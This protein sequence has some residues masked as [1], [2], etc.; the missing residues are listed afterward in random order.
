ML[1]I[2]EKRS[3]TRKTCGRGSSS[4]PNRRVGHAFIAAMLASIW[5]HVK[6][7]CSNIHFTPYINN[8]S[9]VAFCSSHSSSSM[10]SPDLSNVED[11]PRYF[12]VH[13]DLV[14]LYGR[15]REDNDVHHRGHENSRRSPG[16]MERE[17]TDQ[18]FTL[19]KIPS[20]NGVSAE[21]YPSDNEFCEKPASGAYGSCMLNR[22]GEKSLL[23][24]CGDTAYI[25]ES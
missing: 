7:Y 20:E 16:D 24:W 22:G 23:R 17:L 14:T 3:Q 25:A 19:V 8:F 13:Q 11:F 9:A 15:R 4:T 2:V 18:Y 21:G 5:I 6:L 12:T 10:R 1:E